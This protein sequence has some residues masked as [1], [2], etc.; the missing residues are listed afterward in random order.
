[1]KNCQS[2]HT[3]SQ[4]KKDNEIIILTH[5]KLNSQKLIKKNQGENRILIIFITD[6]CRLQT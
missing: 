5:L 1:M 3:F 4:E 6:F 2:I